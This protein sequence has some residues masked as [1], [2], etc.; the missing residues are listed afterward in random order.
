MCRSG[1]HNERMRR[2]VASRC[3]R[4]GRRR[5]GASAAWLLATYTALWGCGG[6]TVVIDQRAPA[7]G[8]AGAA[9][10][11]APGAGSAP[12][13]S[14]TVVSA[15]PVADGIAEEEDVAGGDPPLTDILAQGALQVLEL[16][17]ASCH[18]GGQREGGFGDVLDVAGLIAGGQVV[19]GS[20]ATSPLLSRMLDGSMPPAGV[21]DVQLTSGEISLVQRFIDE[22][23]SGP[24]P[25]CDALPF[26]S[27]DDVYAAMSADIS[28]RPADERPFVRYFGLTY[29]SNARRCGPALEVQRHALFKLLNSVS[30]ATEVSVPEAIDSSGLVYRIDLRSYGWNRAIDLEDDAT[31]DFPDGWSAI[32]SGVGSYAPEFQGPDADAVKRET[33]V[34]VPLLPAH[35]FVQASTLG[36]L[37]YS[38]IGA[39]ANVDDTQAALGIDLQA[40]EEDDDLQR[41]GFSHATPSS[42][43]DMAFLR[44]EQ[45]VQDRA[46]W[47]LELQEW[48]DAESIYDDPLGSD[49]GA[50]HQLIFNLPNGMQAYYV[51]GGQ[52]QRLSEIAMGCVGNCSRPALLNAA[53]CHGCHSIGIIPITDRVR[54]FAEEYARQFDSETLASVLV[55]YPEQ[56]ALDALL[57]QDSEVHLRAVESAGVPRGAPDPISRVYLQF[58]LDPLDLDRAAAELGVPRDALLANL[59]RLDARLSALGAPNGSVERATFTDALRSSLCALHAG[60]RNRPAACP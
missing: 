2:G 42:H 15:P 60:T 26:V 52:G 12:N 39:R 4:L 7:D 13:G 41:A 35:A 36:D 5:Q 47:L 9:S 44:L 28:T 6:K 22:L 54:S 11:G 45:P 27:N 14:V 23:R 37:Y 16:Y 40:A 25:V 18:G 3:P 17:C 19:P 38:L 10:D 33:G 21:R 34:A 1:V 30:T 48:G 20:S 57:A 55:Q 49:R 8:F 32:V 43:D 50:P 46:L 56:A 59:G 24:A 53:G 58:E 31:V 29:A 51:A